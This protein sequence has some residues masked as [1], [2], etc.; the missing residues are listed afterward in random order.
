MPVPRALSEKGRGSAFLPIAENLP[1]R[2]RGWYELIRNPLEDHLAINFL[3]GAY[4]E[5]IGREPTRDFFARALET[6]GT[7]FRVEDESLAR[8]PREGPLVVVANHPFG[9]I[10]GM[11]L[12]ALLNSLRGDARL[13]GNELLLQLPALAPHVIA[14][15]PFGGPKAKQRNLA[16]M[17]AALSWLREGHCLGV[18]PS[19]EVAHYTRAEG[20]IVDPPW[21]PHVARLVRRTGATVVPMFFPGRTGLTFNAAGMLH[22]RLRTIL[23]PRE[24]ARLSGRNLEVRIGTPLTPKVLEPYQTEEELTQ[25]LRLR[26]DVL[27]N[28]EEPAK[29]RKFPR[30]L[31]PFNVAT[32]PEPESLAEAIE[33]TLLADDIAQLPTSNRLHTHG[34]FA[35]FLATSEELPHVLPEIG[36]LRELTF[37]SVYEGTGFAR[38][39]DRFDERYRHLFV[40]DFS[41]Q[42][43]AGAYRLGL[44]DELL[45]EGPGG[46]Y[47]HTLF[48]LKRAFFHYLDPAIEL[49]RSFIT[50]DYQR[51]HATLALLWKGIGAFVVANPRYRRLF[52]PVS[53]DKAYQTLSKDLIV[54]FLS[55][56]RRD[57]RLARLVKP[58]RPHRGHRLSELEKMAPGTLLHDIDDVSALIS[59]IE[60][61]RG[62][63]VLLRHYLKLNAKVLAFNV[64]PAFNDALDG[65][66]VTDLDLVDERLLKHFMGAEGLSRFRSYPDSRDAGEG[67]P[68]RAP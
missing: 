38:D 34:D 11:V 48:R 58:R 7:T 13:L 4:E 45:A 60:H 24:L 40:W 51:K 59:D 21:S 10:E 2:W 47:T 56:L 57:E 30:S 33:P 15:D 1:D 63:P 52:G 35:V 18:F 65:L 53:I 46:L 54:Q 16:G 3:R 68:G 19:G 6:I 42:A 41:R 43:I 66:M 23:L 12:G 67:E 32:N 5:T 50:P 9:G 22:P 64:D 44:T 39:L 28:L 25:F 27:R 17:K 62:A 29:T 36:R 14:V 61:G 37:R 20:R 26:T 55:R 49:G 31:R 8:I